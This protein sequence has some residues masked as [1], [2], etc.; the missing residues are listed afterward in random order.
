MRDRQRTKVYAW[1]DTWGCA[2]NR[3]LKLA[4]ARH[5]VRWACGQYGIKP[6]IVRGHYRV[7]GGT[8]F[9]QPD[10]HIIEFRKRHL[11][12]W[13]SLHEAAHAICDILLDVEEAHSPQWLGIFLALLEKAKV[14]PGVALRASADAARLSYIPSGR[15]GPRKI[16][17]FYRRARRHRRCYTF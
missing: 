10:D 6:P 4:G 3:G 13:V 7:R 15:I 17:K 1:E 11:N 8:S 14:A 5:W 16:R 12:I 9:Y 2:S